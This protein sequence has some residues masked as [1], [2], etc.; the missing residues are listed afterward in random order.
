MSCARTMELLLMLAGLLAGT[1]AGPVRSGGAPNLRLDEQRQRN[2]RRPK[3]DED[4]AYWLQNMIWY[5]RFTAPE[6]H[7]A[8][9]L[10]EREI[11]AA[12]QKFGIRPD[13]RPARAKEAPLLVLPYPG[14]RHP[15]NAGS[16]HD[17]FPG[18]GR[19]RRTST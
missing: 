17:Q 15:R 13:N 10:S 11:A 9:G 19:I 14:G 12:Q 5:H 1:T 18:I 7:A 6:A 16:S 2:L 8:T 3:N 4:L